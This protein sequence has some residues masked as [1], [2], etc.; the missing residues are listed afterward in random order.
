MVTNLILSAMLTSIYPLEIPDDIPLSE[1]WFVSELVE[2]DGKTLQIFYRERPLLKGCITEYQEFVDGELNSEG[3]RISLT[4]CGYAP[5]YSAEFHV[6]DDVDPEPFVRALLEFNCQDVVS[7]ET[8]QK[9]KWEDLSSMSLFK[10]KGRFAFENGPIGHLSLSFDVASK[11]WTA[12]HYPES[13]V[14]PTTVEGSSLQ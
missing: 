5:A 9:V 4:W 14:H 1:I 11:K 8:W 13:L 2:P 12:Q 6:D 3:S 7:C 10:H